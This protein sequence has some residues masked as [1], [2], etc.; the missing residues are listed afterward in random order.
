LELERWG[1]PALDLHFVMKS[2]ESGTCWEWPE[3]IFDEES[4]NSHKGE[5]QTEIIGKM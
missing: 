5:R 4:I 2:E 1:V 3:R